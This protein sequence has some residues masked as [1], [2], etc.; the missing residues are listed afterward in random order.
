MI[1]PVLPVSTACS[2]GFFL[3]NFHLRTSLIL[4]KL[5]NIPL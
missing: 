5:L 3:V 2:P 1:R 4:H